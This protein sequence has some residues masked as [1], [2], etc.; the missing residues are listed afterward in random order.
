M[1]DTTTTERTIPAPIPTE[2]TRAFW[3]AANAGR[4]LVK[5]CQACGQVHWYPRALCPFCFSSDTVWQ[6]G[7]GRGTIYSFS[8]MRQAPQPFVVAFVTLEEGPTMLTNIVDC[9]FDTLAI[10]QAVQVVFKPTS[11]AQQIPVFRPA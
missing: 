4:F 2:D 3:E 10:G 5:R 7:A 6:D 8:V 1:G 9:D 11:G